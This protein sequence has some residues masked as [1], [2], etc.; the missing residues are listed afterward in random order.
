MINRVKLS[1]A[2]D[3]RDVPLAEQVIRGFTSSRGVTPAES[4]A[5]ATSV[6][7]IIE[8]VNANAYGQS[9]TGEVQLELEAHHGG[10][11]C[12]IMD[13]G[14]PL[15]SFGGQLG[16]VPDEL[17][18]LPAV[19]SHLSLTNLGHEG[20]RL[21]ITFPV[22]EIRVDR[23]TPRAAYL[24]NLCGPVNADDVEYRKARAEDA[25]DIAQLICS[26]Y[27]MVYIH[28]DFYR[29]EWIAE[30][31]ESG[32]IVSFVAV[33]GGDIVGYVALLGDS[34]RMVREGGAGIVH[35]AVRGS[36]VV[37]KIVA[38]A[39]QHMRE[40]NEPAAMSHAVTNHLYSQRALHSNGF[41]TVGI[42]LGI[43]PLGYDPLID[44]RVRIIRLEG[45]T[46][47]AATTINYLPLTVAVSE[48]NFPSRYA[49]PLSEAYANLKVSRQ[50]ANIEKA[51]QDL[52]DVAPVGVEGTRLGGDAVTIITVARWDEH[53]RHDLVKAILDS[54]EQSDALYCDIDLASHTQAELDLIVELL[55]TYDFFY[56]G[57]VFLGQRSHDHIRLQSLLTPFEKVETDEVMLDGSF[58]Q[59]LLQFILADHHQ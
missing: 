54:R 12:F 10:I 46:K 58:A 59:D 57:L 17:S 1:I 40:H 6:C 49:V 23:S 45:V 15:E 34:P 43:A 16:A 53:S 42:Q 29:P 39:L 36:G 32:S 47:R 35:P 33:L 52:D 48:V 4:E 8:W 44:E 24:P 30:Q 18:D 7:Q 21:S 22:T 9:L 56:C 11:A 38:G 51:R 27:G 26:H 2:S 41:R 28:G 14:L 3:P 19:V 50:P 13:Q 5:I 55:R 37:S 31:I 25:D 20:K